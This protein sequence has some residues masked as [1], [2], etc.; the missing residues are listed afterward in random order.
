MG[1]T[2]KPGH[3]VRRAG[4]KPL[5][6]LSV[7]RFVLVRAVVA[8]L[9]FHVF[10]AGALFAC[11]YVDPPVTALQIQREVEAVFTREKYRHVQ[12]PVPLGRISRHLQHAVVAAEDGGFFDHGGIDW[13]ELQNAVEENERRK[14]WRGG[15]TITQQ[16][17][18]NLFFGTRLRWV[19]KPLDFTLA[20]LAD[21]I[22]GKRRTLA[23][24]LNVV[25][26]GRGVY[27]AEA[28]SRHFY[29]TSVASLDR[30]RAARLAACLPAPRRRHP[31]RM[32]R[33]SR[34]ILHR[35]AARG[36]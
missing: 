30:E 4:T 22:L 12:A 17:V 19:S 36:W 11:R 28:A 10:A 32:N 35:M 18:K 13:D 24:Y 23:I 34:I 3:R 9:A 26:W 33:Y 14:R 20:P 8:V 29:G 2:D 25:E 5:T 16:L 15:S 7:A 21:W 1:R 6:A 27:G 31:D